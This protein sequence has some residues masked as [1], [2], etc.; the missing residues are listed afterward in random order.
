M[1]RLVPI[2]VLLVVLTAGCIGTTET[3]G[4]T[5][6]TTAT[7]TTT[8]S[9]HE[10]TPATTTADSTTD[11]TGALAPGVTGEGVENTSRLLDAHAATLLDRGFEVAVEWRNDLDGDTYYYERQLVA[12]PGLQRFR[13]GST[14]TMASGESV[15]HAWL[16]ETT[17]LLVRVVAN[18]ETEY[19]TNPVGAVGSERRADFV[20]WAGEVN[21]LAD[22]VRDGEFAVTR[23]NET[24]DATRYVLAAQDVP[25]TH[26]FGERDVE[27]TV[28]EDGVIHR[29]T[30]TGNLTDGGAFRFTYRVDRLGVESVEE[31]AWVADAPTPVDARPTL[32]F[33]N[34]TTPY[35]VLQN[36]G[37]DA[38]P[39]G[40]EVTVT[41]DGTEYEVALD[42]PLPAGEERALY[43]DESGDIRVAPIDAVPATR[44]AMP[45]EAEFAI[46]TGEGL[47]LSQGGMGFG[48]ESASEGSGSGSGSSGSESGGS[49]G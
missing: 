44:T 42:A 17:T 19:R 6:T 28:D 47:L 43:L 14:I 22:L 48:C 11:P 41:L 32:D 31:P 40:T 21:R 12:T 27:L 20:S 38:L 25:A 13:S 18:D 3:P 35:L 1:A 24:G 8:E 15:Q 29:L 49:G 36:E 7:E 34:C 2:A 10:T 33:E 46:T 5:D 16:D 26:Q 39:V 4:A 9:P 45:N 23:T 30:A 37:P